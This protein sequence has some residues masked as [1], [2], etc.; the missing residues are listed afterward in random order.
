[1]TGAL[2]AVASLRRLV[3]AAAA[4]EPPSAEDV[5]RLASG[6]EAYL[7]RA[8][9]GLT[10][11]AAL[12]LAATPGGTPWW[13]AERTA[14]RDAVLRELAAELTGPVATRAQA[15]ALLVRRY[16]GT[17]WPH[18]RRRGEPFPRTPERELLFKLF[19]L[20][21]DPPTSIRRLTDIIAASNAAIGAFS[22]RP[23]PATVPPGPAG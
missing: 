23:A 2:A 5:L 18:D 1:L 9:D 7:E 4:G 19:R 13:R 10:L 11:E 12:G 6:V 14:A 21:P 16:A 8:P 15:L 3:A 17:G 22:L 20:D